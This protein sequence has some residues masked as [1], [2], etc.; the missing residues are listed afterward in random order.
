MT[1]QAKPQTKEMT[2]L[3]TPIFP[4][5]GVGCEAFLLIAPSPFPLFF[6]PLYL[7]KPNTY[8]IYDPKQYLC[9][10]LC[11]YQTALSFARRI[12]W[13]CCPRGD[14]LSYR[15]RFCHKLPHALFQSRLFGCRFFLH[16]IGFCYRI[17]LRRPPKH[18]GC[19]GLFKAKG[20]PT[21]S[22]GGDRSPFWRTDVLW[23]S[24]RIF[25]SV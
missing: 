22:H 18:H 9:G 24:H 11:R 15:R 23:A 2:K 20:Y 3:F 6:L 16:A 7:I 25:E 1:S 14:L 5:R 4:W 13:R 8:H 10:S 17:C 21:A 19:Y 12:A